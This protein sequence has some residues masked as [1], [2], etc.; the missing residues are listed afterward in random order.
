MGR[1]LI[2]GRHIPQADRLDRILEFVRCLM[3]GGAEWL[4]GAFPEA[5]DR[6][7][8]RQA[9][10]ILG[11]VDSGGCLTVDGR[12]VATADSEDAY[13]WLAAVFEHSVIGKAWLK[14]A[15]AT[16]L[17]ELRAEDAANFLADRSQLSPSTRDRRAST[18]ASWLRVLQPHAR[19]TKPR[20]PAGSITTT[21]Q[22][23]FVS[24][25]PNPA[26][27]HPQEGQEASWPAP[28]RFPHNEESKKVGEVVGRDIQASA[29]A[30][31]I[32]GY[33]SLDRLLE[34]LETRSMGTG[35]VRLLL[36]SEPFPSSRSSFATSVDFREEVRAYWF[37]RG[38]SVH[39]SGAVLHARDLVTSG[40]VEVRT[41]PGPRRLHAKMYVTDKAVI[42]GSSNYTDSGLRLQAEANVRFSPKEAERHAEARAFAEKLWVGGKD[43]RDWF[44][45]LLNGLLRSVTWEEALARACAEVLD[46]EWARRYA[47]P[48]DDV[49]RKLWRHQIQGIS[50][51]SWILQNVGSV[52]VADPTGSGKTKMGAWIIR[53]AFDRHYRQGYLQD[54]HPLV[55]TPP[56]VAGNWD[57]ALA[58]T[59]V[60]LRVE[61]HGHL[62]S[63]RATRHEILKRQIERTALLAVDEAHNFIRTS[64]RTKTLRSHYAE[65]V[66]LFTA[67]PINRG[68][69]DLY[70][71]LGLL[72]ADQIPEDAFG[73]LSRLDRFERL[74]PQ[75]ERQQVLEK[76]R[77]EI[78]RFTVR[79]TRSQLD[80]IARTHPDEYKIGDRSA[81]Y[82]RHRAKYYD[83]H[84]TAEDD[85]I[86]T[87]IRLLADRLHGVALI[88]KELRSYGDLTED[89]YLRR[90]VSSA[91]A[92]ARYHVLSSMRSSRAA[93]LE[94]AIG[95]AAAWD[96]LLGAWPPGKRPPATGDF[97]ARSHLKAKRL[98]KWELRIAPPDEYTWLR[99]PEE[100]ARHAEEDARIYERI[101][102]LAQHLSDSRE[103]AK[104]Q[105]LEKCCREHG[106]VIAFDGYL[107]SLRYFER[108]LE[109]RGLP[110]EVL[111]GEGGEAA[112]Q[113]AVRRLG[114]ASE[115]KE[116][117]ALC[118]DAFSEGLNLQRASCVVHLDTPTVVRIAEQ[119]AGRVDR[120]DSPHDEVTIWWPR[121][122]RAFAPRRRDVF[123]E[124]HEMVRDL[125]GANVVHPEDAEDLDLS[126]EDLV[127]EIQAESEKQENEEEFFDAFREVRNL[128]EGKT[129]VVPTAIYESM[130]KTQAEVV[131]CVSV[132]ESESPWC[133]LAVGGLDRAAPRW[134]FFDGL[135]APPEFDLFDI[136]KKLRLRLEA[137][138]ES[139]TP[140]EQSNRLLEHFLSKLRKCEEQLE[141][142]PARKRRALKV[143]RDHLRAD[144]LG[145]EDVPEVRERR[146]LEARLFPADRR[147]PYPDPA[148]VADTWIR[149]LRP[150][151]R[152]VLQ[153]RKG[154]L[155][156]KIDDLRNSPELERFDAAMLRK[157]FA[158]VPMLRPVEERIVAMI[159]G[160]NDGTATPGRPDHSSG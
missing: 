68:P 86:A 41:Y 38:I 33:S 97:R 93:L 122:A 52:L 158:D 4:E 55:V 40:T 124:R 148:S 110:V 48:P 80:A 59:G 95:T 90:V 103:R 6:N 23:S 53:G 71:I 1:V 83:C 156:W 65:N 151:I 139:R 43:D 76:A 58:D 131:S 153:S 26:T 37:R 81:R 35:K 25:A 44:L 78:R 100:F 120:M 62:S 96:A 47:P 149:L 74:E 27:P 45:E 54:P 64:E 132:L 19:A 63:K 117:I 30:L 50:Q 104:M 121:D 140:D 49:G 142:L 126:I 128:V 3:G 138:P 92:L 36:G 31:I 42:V 72:G 141:L 143:L 155:P 160:V 113:R 39:L 137:K 109:A 136:P 99:D 111:T 147:E 16:S 56:Q 12:R 101:G 130:R 73:V 32:A 77:Q 91:K 154:R 60:P 107:I 8:Y 144:S 114:L 125:I 133:F 150:V 10:W 129:A 20:P 105:H 157:A 108:E 102:E 51:A 22:L 75:E 29:D 18:L 159:L 115:E 61:S 119:R 152:N 116:L 34:L 79:R 123:R 118:T 106:P 13:R 135:N 70:A 66:I 145:L 7:Y 134:V 5:R 88:G 82:P 2:D 127:G 24:S 112:K 14:W 94:H 84:S 21:E 87:E 69:R 67:T 85:R 146:R 98:P 11:L 57:D 28:E 17:R 15:K 46:G 89:A 9:A